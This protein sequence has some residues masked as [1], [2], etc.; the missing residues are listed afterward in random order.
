MAGAE[1][2]IFS[3]VGA[4]KRQGRAEKRRTRKD[5]PVMYQDKN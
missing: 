4:E 1:T 3:E 2:C 5:A